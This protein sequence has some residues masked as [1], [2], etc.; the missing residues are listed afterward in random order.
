MK[1][2]KQKKRRVN[3]YLLVL[4]I[5]LFITTSV[6]AYFSIFV[7]NGVGFVV[8]PIQESVASLT[9]SLTRGINT[10]KD[11]DYVKNENEELKLQNE[12]L[13]LEVS[14]L[15]QVEKENEELT[16]LLDTKSSY[17]ELPTIT[18]KIIGRDNSNWQNTLIIDKGIDDGLEENMIVLAY[19]GLL[20][21][22][23][24]V[25]KYSS[26]VTTVLDD[27]S[28]ISVMT[29]RTNEYALLK[30]DVTMMQEGLCRLEYYDEA[31]DILVGDKI[32]TSNISSLYPVGIEIGVVESLP[33]ASSS[34]VQT[35]IIKLN[36]DFKEL[37]TLLVVTEL[38]T[39]SD[40]VKE[41]TISSLEDVTKDISRGE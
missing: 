29:E 19:G 37:T 5:V 13:S 34:L 21:R 35:A 36:V 41:E 2:I 14:R 32:V 33:N 39:R 40:E 25:S 6:F 1:K 30:G 27:S 38:F 7:H 12:E 15:A 31:A 16:A 20:G 22:V 10:F 24:E 9:E 11:K 18:A 8:V 4:A 3:L 28:S 23:I 26:K 17:P